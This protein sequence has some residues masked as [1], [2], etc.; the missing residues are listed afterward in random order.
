MNEL[1]H[2]WTKDYLTTYAPP[3]L[4][5]D[6][7]FKYLAAFSDHLNLNKVRDAYDTAKVLEFFDDSLNQTN[8][9]YCISQASV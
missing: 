1:I 7:F 9:T 8:G 5:Q 3:T 6:S 4:D 2:T